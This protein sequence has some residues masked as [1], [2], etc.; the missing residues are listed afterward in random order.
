MPFASFGENFA[1]F[2]TTP[3]ENLFIQEYMLRAPGNHVKVYLYGL[4]HCYHP[5]ESMSLARMA[6]DLSLEEDEVFAIYQYWERMGLVRRVADQPPRYVY[7]NLKHLQL[8]GAAETE[9]IYKYKDFNETLHNLFDKKRK[10]YD[11][12]YRRVYEW[13]EVLGLPEA[14]VIMLIRHATDLYGVRFS[15]EKAEGLAREWSQMGV[16]TIEDAEEATQGAK[17]ELTDLKK[18]L[19][20]LG[21]R[22]EP[23][24]DEQA[25]YRKWTRQWGFTPEAVLEACAETTKGAPTMA[26]LNGILERQYGLGIRDAAQ[27]KRQL[28]QEAD[29]AEPVRRVN[30]ALGR[31]AAPTAQDIAWMTRYLGY[32]FDPGAVEL[33]AVVAH[34]NGGRGLEDVERRLEAWR[35]KGLYTRAEIEGYLSQVKRGNAAIATVF[36]V[37]GEQRRPTASDRTLYEKWTGEWGLPLEVIALAAASAGHAQVKMPFIDA[38]LSRWRAQGIT[39]LEAA[40]REQAQHNQKPISPPQAGAGQAAPRPVREVAQHRYE[41]RNYSKEELDAL[42]F[43]VF[44]GEG[45]EEE[46]P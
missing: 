14:V 10:L 46:K 34:H 41:Q 11:Q 12:D 37:C 22:R 18:L 21:Q 43:D 38:I 32:G 44:A 28:A 3:V 27:L 7:H 5:T 4:M 13:I 39:T 6:K 17:Q 23:S 19:R 35:A 30:Q 20:R 42:L 26:Y 40:R 31:R 2:D 36:E 25:L 16:T 33:A 8:M 9:S 15:F 45:P 24:M 1:L 29:A